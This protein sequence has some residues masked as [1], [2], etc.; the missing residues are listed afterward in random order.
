[1]YFWLVFGVIV[2]KIIKCDQRYFDSWTKNYHKHTSEIVTQE[3]LASVASPM[4][5]YRRF[6]D[7]SSTPSS[8]PTT[9]DIDLVS[10]TPKSEYEFSLTHVSTPSKE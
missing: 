2:V 3:M 7:A 6:E 5:P 1:M 10:S 9:T 8:P 4:T